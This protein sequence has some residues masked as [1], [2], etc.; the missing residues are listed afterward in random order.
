MPGLISSLYSSYSGM[1]VS[2]M[3]IQTTSHNINNMN[4]PGYTRQKVVQSQRGA[5]SYP[6]S[7]S[8]LGAGQLG[9][10][11]QANDIVRVRNSFHDFQYRNESHEY[12]EIAKRYENLRHM[13]TIFNEPSDSSISSAYNDFYMS[14][15]ELSK[16]PGD[17]GSI[18][19]V[20]QNSKYLAQNISSVTNKLESM[21]DQINKDIEDNLSAINSNI[22]R[23][24]ALE[25]D[26]KLVEGSGKTPNDL[27][28]EVD[29][30]IDDLSFRMNVT[31]DE[32]KSFIDAA[33]EPGKEVIIGKDNNGNPTLKIATKEVYDKD[34]KLVGTVDTNKPI[35]TDTDGDGV[36]DRL[37][38]YE[39]V[40]RNGQKVGEV[41]VDA[42][43]DR[44]G[45]ATATDSKGNNI[46]V[47]ANTQTID[48]RDASGE[49]E[50]SFTMLN[51]IDEYVDNMKNMAEHLAENVND[52]IENNT[53]PQI[54]DDIFIFDPD[55]NPML[56]VA[57]N[58]HDILGQIPH[59]QMVN[60]AKEMYD[61]KDEK[62]VP[63]LDSNGAPV[64]DENGDPK[65]I[66]INNF[67]NDL[68]QKLGNETQE[69]IRA[70][71]NQSKVLNSIESSRLSIT[72]VSLDEEMVNLIQFQHSYNASAKVISTLDSLLE[73][74][75]NGL[76]R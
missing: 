42:N 54:T 3:N 46:T 43:G 15:H 21:K 53:N 76:K 40:N 65:H 22:D 57:D 1:S 29:R 72:G 61:L 16:R 26:I 10:G 4:T 44:S 52:I 25:K 17:A 49:L 75:I 13:E 30:I 64:L 51:K 33:M 74:V 20:V 66:T 5:Y 6:G 59:D 12:G 56:S 37:D 32:A 9:Q 2:Q 11:V 67:Y 7:N 58:A 35:M 63:V 24:R 39:L 41:A 73:V 50:G 45:Q 62:V 8:Y 34:G 36:G 69:A 14:W 28:D 19:V 48:I 55:G 38:G 68:I 71:S 70:E 31:T 23:L 60:I 27:Y 47:P 18:D